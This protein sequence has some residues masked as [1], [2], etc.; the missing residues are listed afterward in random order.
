MNN[1][2]L[3]VY[4]GVGDSAKEVVVILHFFLCSISFLSNRGRNRPLC[5][6]DRECARKSP[7]V[8]GNVV[9]LFGW[10]FS[11]GGRLHK[12][13]NDGWWAVLLGRWGNESLVRRRSDSA[14]RTIVVVQ[15]NMKACNE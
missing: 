13:R 9:D 8:S 14:L 11:L 7:W 5:R 12:V 4:V 6:W 3:D 15:L 1:Q 2:S 10:W